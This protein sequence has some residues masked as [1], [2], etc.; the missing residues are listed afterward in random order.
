[1]GENLHSPAT[2]LIRPG[3]VS[4][5]FKILYKPVLQSKFLESEKGYPGTTKK[6]PPTSISATKQNHSFDN[7]YAWV[8]QT[9]CTW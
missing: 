9:H 6:D 3:E 5:G 8:A 2:W 4:T 1:M 7:V